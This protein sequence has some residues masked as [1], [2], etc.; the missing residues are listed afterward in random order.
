M[1]R[2]SAVAPASSEENL[3]HCWPCVTTFVDWEILV[4]G[5]DLTSLAA[6]GRQ[7]EGATVLR[8]TIPSHPSAR[9]STC[10]QVAYLVSTLGSGAHAPKCKVS[11]FAA[12]SS[13]RLV[14]S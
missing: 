7:G 12:A 9:V 11:I 8:P 6:A 10:G 4:D 5:W 13:N 14:Q 1:Q 2:T 3:A